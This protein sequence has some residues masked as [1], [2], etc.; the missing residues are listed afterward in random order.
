M[1]LARAFAKL[2]VFLLGFLEVVSNTTE[3]LWDVY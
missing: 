1:N 2:L 3:I